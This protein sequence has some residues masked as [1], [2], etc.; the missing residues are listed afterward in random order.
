MFEKWLELRF[1]DISKF[2]SPFNQSGAAI[3]T[4]HKL[5]RLFISQSDCGDVQAQKEQTEQNK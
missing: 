5:W 4:I 1:N 2:E 3:K